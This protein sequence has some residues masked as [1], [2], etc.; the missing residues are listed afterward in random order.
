MLATRLAARRMTL[1]FAFV[2]RGCVCNAGMGKCWPAVSFVV[3]FLLI[4]PIGALLHIV[5]FV[6]KMIFDMWIRCTW[7]QGALTCP[8]DAVT[9]SSSRVR[10]PAPQGTKGTKKR[11]K[12]DRTPDTVSMDEDEGNEHFTISRLPSPEADNVAASFD[13]PNLESPEITTPANSPS[14]FKKLMTKGV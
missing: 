4:G 12:R 14:F 3:R 6:L 2:I 1:G 7:K 10:V 9:R 8:L 5:I 13:I 11:N